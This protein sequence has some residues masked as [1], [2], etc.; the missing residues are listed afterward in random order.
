MLSWITATIRPPA[1]SASRGSALASQDHPCGAIYAWEFE[2]DGQAFTVKGEGPLVFNS[3][4]HVLNAALD[5]V[6]VGYVP[7][8]LA[9]PHIADGRLQCILQPWSP[10]FQGYHLYY[11]NRRQASPAF[12]AFV[13]VF[14]YRG[15]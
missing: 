8:Q 11:P 9:A 15:A 10:R 6:G 7:E 4:M 5:G 12:M 14:R 1:A 3:I 13:E 2:K